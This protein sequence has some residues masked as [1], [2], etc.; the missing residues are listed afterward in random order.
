[1]KENTGIKPF[2]V[3]NIRNVALVQLTY[4]SYTNR[5][6]VETFNLSVVNVVI[7]AIHN[8]M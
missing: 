2:N 5:F 7:Y 4:T 3:R 6:T 1:M 8:V